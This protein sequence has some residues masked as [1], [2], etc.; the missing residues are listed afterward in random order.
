MNSETR[1]ELA[2]QLLNV[3]GG[4]VHQICETFGLNVNEFL[5]SDLQSDF[6]RAMDFQKGWFA[7][8]TCN[9]DYFIE[10]IIPL[11]KGNLVFFFGCLSGL[12]CKYK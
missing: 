7:A 8:R 10:K 2:L 4:T 3:K 11:Y 6:E 5:Y 9:H 1:V 12:N